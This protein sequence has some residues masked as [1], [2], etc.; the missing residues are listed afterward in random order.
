[1][2]F[3][4]GKKLKELRLAKDVTQDALAQH[5]QISPQAISKWERGTGYPDIMLLPRIAAFFDVSVDELLGTGEEIRRGKIEKWSKESFDYCHTGQIAKNYE[6]WKNAYNEYPNDQE[7]IVN[8]MYA[9]FNY[10]NVVNDVS[11]AEKAVELGELLL[12][13]SPDTDKR[14]S[15]RQVLVILNKELGNTAKAR[16]YA[17]AATD[18]TTSREMLLNHVLDGEEQIEHSQY[19]VL[20]LIDTAASR[21]DYFLADNYPHNEAIEIWKYVIGLYKGL[22]SRGD[23]GFFNLRMSE[24]SGRLSRRYAMAGER[25]LCL[26]E[27]KHSVEY[28]KAFEEWAKG[29]EIVKH[30]SPLLN[31]VD[32]ARNYMLGTDKK[33]SSYTLMDL[34]RPVYDPYREDPEFVRIRSELESL[35][36]DSTK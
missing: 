15:A 36:V 6:L 13:K 10:R 35:G 7:V 19:L 16:E 5:L 33:M 11:I 22:F 31:R 18:M 9:L 21:I 8:Y 23:L 2:E 34:D 25:E 24:Y 32:M 3:S 27:L 1:M 30:T 12:Q 14:G 28:I 26:E 4:F 17:E 20:N 29:S